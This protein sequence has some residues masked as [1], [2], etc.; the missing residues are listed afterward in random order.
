MSFEEGFG[1]PKI[2]RADD[3]MLNEIGK[4]FFEIG[5][6][7]DIIECFFIIGSEGTLA[8]DYCS[9]VEQEI[10]IDYG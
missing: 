6:P 8:C 4:C 1:A 2:V 10:S 3:L 5:L 7:L 9:V